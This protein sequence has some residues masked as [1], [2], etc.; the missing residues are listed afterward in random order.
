MAKSRNLQGY[1]NFDSGLAANPEHWFRKIQLQKIVDSAAA[2]ALERVARPNGE[3][4]LLNRGVG[5]DT[6]NT[7]GKFHLLVHFVQNLPQSIERH[8]G[9]IAH[10]PKTSFFVHIGREDR[11]ILLVDEGRPL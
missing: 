5:S 6:W 8:P 2:D 10:L 11:P 3:C 7:A 4:K 1:E 9:G